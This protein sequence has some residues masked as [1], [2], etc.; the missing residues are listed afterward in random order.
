MGTVAQAL[1]L[2]PAALLVAV[3]GGCAG[4]A[5]GLWVREPLGRAEQA[6]AP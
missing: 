6:Q 3:L 2:G 5:M 1:A 4:V